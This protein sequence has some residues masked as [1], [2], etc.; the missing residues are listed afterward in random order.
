MLGYTRGHFS[1]LVAMETD[2]S[3]EIGAGAH[4]P[5][6]DNIHETYLPL[7]DHEGRVLT[8]HFLLQSEV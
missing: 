2:T 7:V 8:V 5:S 1:A 3:H 4:V 6:T